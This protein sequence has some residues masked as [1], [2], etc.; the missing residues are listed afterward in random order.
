MAHQRTAGQAAPVESGSATG[1]LVHSASSQVWPVS[2]GTRRWAK[3]SM[4]ARLRSRHDSGWH[5]PRMRMRVDKIGILPCTIGTPSFC[6]DIFCIYHFVKAGND[7]RILCCHTLPD[8]AADKG[9]PSSCAYFH[10]PLHQP[11]AHICF[12]FVDM[13]CP[14]SHR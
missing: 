10:Y 7:A 2:E 12:A 14:S 9:L 1:K 5:S 13:W 8:L 6:C 3:T 4:H 11:F